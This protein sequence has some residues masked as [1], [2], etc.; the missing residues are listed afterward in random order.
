MRTHLRFCNKN[1]CVTR[2][3]AL[4]EYVRLLCEH[5]S[6]HT[7]T[8]QLLIELL[9]NDCS[10]QHSGMC[11]IEPNSTGEY[12][13]LRDLGLASLED[14]ESP[15]Q[16]AWS[17][18]LLQTRVGKLIRDFHTFGCDRSITGRGHRLYLKR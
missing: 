9:T 16:K 2:T 10:S 13:V 18:C 11:C 12:G 15:L 7:H 17:L 6:V 1:T 4:S 5:L 14:G 3:L 8:I